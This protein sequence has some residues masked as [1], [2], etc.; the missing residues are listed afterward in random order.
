MSYTIEYN[1]K[2]FRLDAGTVIGDARPLFEATYFL[3]IQ[4]GDN[5]VRPRPRTWCMESVGAHDTVLKDVCERAG[6]RRRRRSTALFRLHDARA[7]HHALPAGA[8]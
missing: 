8:E 5:N 6:A 1:R 2:C 4:Q 7:L 3:F